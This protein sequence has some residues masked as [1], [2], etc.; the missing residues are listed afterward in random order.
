M[1][2]DS[3]V[4]K[5][6]KS[7]HLEI[8]YDLDGYIL[9][10]DGQVHRLSWDKKSIV[11]NLKN[12]EIQE[13]DDYS[14]DLIFGK[15]KTLYI[16]SLE[17]VD[18]K[19]FIYFNNGEVEERPM[20]Y[21]ILSDKPYGSGWNK[22]EGN[23]HY[24]Y[25]RRFND[26]IKYS[27]AL[28][29]LKKIDADYFNIW[30][31][32]EQAMIYHGIT[33]FKGLKVE[34]VSVL[35]F[36][37][38]ASGLHHDSDS[39]VF[40]ITNTFRDIH[41][42]I[43]KKLFRVDEYG[44][45]DVAMIQD[46][47]DWVVKK[48]PTVITGHNI[49]SYD[50]P[51]IQYCYSG[52]NGR[53]DTLPIGKF[54]VEVSFDRF[55]SKFRVDGGNS[56]DYTKIQVPGR[57][58]I[59]GMFLAVK[60]D[61]GRNFPSW[62]LKPIAEYL[63][64][65][66]EGRQF[67]DASKIKDNWN[68]PIEREKI[69]DYGRDDADDSLA[70]YDI[71]I[72]SIF[73]MTQSVP[74]PYQIMGLSA[75]GAQ[76]NAVMTRAYLQDS[77][78]IPKAEEKEYV[79]GGMSYGV[80]GI[81]TNVAKWD[82][83][84]YYPS[85]VLAF[86]IYD[87]VK[88]PKKYY[89]K[90]V[91]YFTEKRFEQ[92]RKY[93]ETKDKYYDDLQISSKEFINS[94]YG[95]LGTSGLHFNSFENAALITKCARAG[96]Q[97]CVKWATGYPIEYWWDEYYDKTTSTQDFEDNSFIDKKAKISTEEMPI[98]NWKLVNIDTDSLSFCKQDG[99]IFTQEEHEQIFKEVNEIMYSPWE[100]DGTFEKLVVLKAK[101][102]ILK[103]GD[104]VKLKGS[105]IT[106][107]SKEPALQ[108]FTKE[109]IDDLLETDG[110]NYIQIYEKYTKEASDIKDISRWCVKK[111]ITKAVLNPE[112]T[113]EQ[114]VAD[115]LEGY[116]ISEGDKVF[117]YSAING[118]R[119]QIKKGEPVFLKDGS[120]KME[121]NKIL[122]HVNDFANDMDIEHYV[123]R[124]YKTLEIFKNVLDVSIVTKYYLKSNLKLLEK[125]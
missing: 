10:I 70:L 115:A 111:S 3:I 45:D 84:S 107:P 32:K 33:M 112:R 83:A 66:K 55:V 67:Y 69:V 81:Y 88:D 105:S 35:S 2:I 36:D 19:I 89:V 1:N 68:N 48:D 46:W 30:N 118:E 40:L 28:K 61:K 63:G 22:L 102:Y 11:E 41:G 116:D 101:N 86:D 44:D 12:I 76:L 26:L 15:D 9:K 125:L 17:V 38:E 92:K 54:G 8:D 34:D 47:C 97:K 13:K 5:A 42:S 16:V 75:S 85:T 79:A 64:I 20:T 98:H 14:N 56:W 104:K 78:S 37:I 106:N 123:K 71:M 91:R 124:V 114:K 80:P 82:A 31:L 94:A 23:Q 108:E 58:I 99:S 96:L 29:K 93:K 122:K 24:K 100:D 119:Q 77:H 18:N 59:D 53:Q 90:M 87:K 51:Y 103:E 49:F 62:G 72:P 95:L 7:S 109:L 50:F 52:R 121:P 74:K 57:H 120:A 4:E 60:Y 21:W 73:Y 117:L 110:A 27:I 6:K 43:T 65:V 25:I 39:K 113:N